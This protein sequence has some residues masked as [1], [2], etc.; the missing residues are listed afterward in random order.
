ML[1]TC[2]VLELGIIECGFPDSVRSLYFGQS[3]SIRV[4]TYRVSVSHS[5]DKYDIDGM[6]TNID[7]RHTSSLPGQSH[8]PYRLTVLQGFA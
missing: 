8:H 4:V 5:W 6:K 2:G 3:S 7:E 1:Q